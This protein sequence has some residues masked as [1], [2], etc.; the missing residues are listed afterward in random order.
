[1]RRIL[2]MIVMMFL[3]FHAY[4]GVWQKCDLT[5][6]IVDRTDEIYAEVLAIR[7]KPHVECPTKGSF[8]TFAPDSHDWQSKLPKKQWPQIGQHWTVRYQYL[9]GACKLDGNDGPCRIKVY[10]KIN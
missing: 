2:I 5:I 1:M 8:I 4:A 7:A 6:Q 9:D 3:S 10:P